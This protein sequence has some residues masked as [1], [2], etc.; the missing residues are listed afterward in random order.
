MTIQLHNT[1]RRALPEAKLKKAVRLVLSEEGGK[2]VSIDAI[3]CGGRM[4]RRINREFLGH[5]Y[6]T[7]T[8]T[9]PYSEGL[10]VEGE[11][12]VSLDE[13]GRNAV[14]F[15]S[16]FEQELLRVTI[17]SVLHLLGYDDASPEQRERMR[18]KEDR[19]L[20]IF[21]AGVSSTEE[22]SQV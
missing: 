8:V 21:G 10:V 16:G 19:Y 11:F 22:R 14:R 12:Y 15:K 13:V 2:A 5:D 3:Y 4:M 9:F 17:H 6:D 1:T 18:Q 7:D 20:R